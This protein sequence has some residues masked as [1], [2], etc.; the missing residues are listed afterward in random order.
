M[1]KEWWISESGFAYDKPHED[2]DIKLTHA[3]D[4]DSYFFQQTLINSLEYHSKEKD[5]EIEKL[6]ED[7][8]LDR[9]KPDDYQDLA[10]QNKHLTKNL[11]VARKASE[12]MY[13][14]LRECCCCSTI[15]GRLISCVYCDCRDEFINITTG[16]SLK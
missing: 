12:K 7:I 16:A 1:S 2:S 3:I 8:R 5:L 4:Y 14:F 13:D 6:K 11:A 10:E 15:D 9:V